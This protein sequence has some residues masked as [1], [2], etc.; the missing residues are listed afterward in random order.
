MNHRVGATEA[1]RKLPELLRGVRSGKRYTITHR[2]RTV[3]ELVPAEEAK[4]PEPAAAVEAMKRFIARRRTI[5][6]VD[7]KA[8]IEY[9]RK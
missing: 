1:R 7:I 3:A 6:G 4:R 2:G 5:R 9:G 8:L